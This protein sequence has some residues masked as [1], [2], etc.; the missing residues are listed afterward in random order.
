MRLIFA[1]TPAAAVPSLEAIATS[2]H[3]LVAV[4]TR[5]DAPRGRGRELAASPVGQRASELRLRVLK[6]E[7][8]KADGLAREL[9]ELSPDCC[10]IVAYGGLIP[11]DLLSVPTY[12]WVNL[13]FSLLPAW[14][15]AAPVHHAIAHGDDITG[16]TTFRLTEGLDNGPVF[17]TVTEPIR[18][19]DTTGDVLGRLARSGADLL[20]HTLNGIERGDLAPQEQPADGVTL[21]PKV[22]PADARVRWQEPA[23][24]IARQIRSN[25]PSPGAWT[26]WADRRLGL[27]PLSS[28]NAEQPEARLPAG[29]V[30][31][32]KHEVWVG[33]GSGDVQLG[34][35]KPAGKGTMSASDWA[36]GARLQDGDQLT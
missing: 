7:S 20:L 4:I 16:A 27:L 28:A 10:P 32:S 19:R 6:P 14:R 21:A 8:P 34:D 11:R 33:T 30:R 17:G 24:T 3:D 22:T 12:G 1:G 5:P 2:H 18:A 35:V 29:V 23:L 31:V 36:R 25:T 9:R 26:Q 13:H 15:G